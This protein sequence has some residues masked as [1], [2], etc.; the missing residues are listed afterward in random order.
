MNFKNPFKGSLANGSRKISLGIFA[1]GIGLA[2]QI[3]TG[4]VSDGLVILLI[5]VY[6][7][8][9]LGNVGEHFASKVVTTDTSGDSEIAEIRQS[10]SK[11]IAYQETSVA[12][13]NYLIS[14]VRKYEQPPVDKSIGA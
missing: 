4:Q 1:M 14:F 9:V 13:L 12:A 5:G 7:A 2:S 6:G 10:L 11:L 8:F 3:W